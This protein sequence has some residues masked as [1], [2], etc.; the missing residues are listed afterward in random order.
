CVCVSET[1][2]QHSPVPLSL[3]HTDTHAHTHTHTHTHRHTRTHTRTNT[4]THT[5]TLSL[6]LTHTHTQSCG[7]LLLLEVRPLLVAVGDACACEGGF[8][9]ADLA[10]QVALF[11]QVVLLPL[12]PLTH[13]LL[14]LHAP[15][16]LASALRHALQP[17]HTHTHTHTHTDID[18]LSPPSCL[19]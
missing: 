4:H 3:T 18:F 11:L 10:L 12:V 2:P 8:H 15:P 17:T 14:P 7:H 6:S 19:L 13:L 5:H 1:P 16:P 9:V